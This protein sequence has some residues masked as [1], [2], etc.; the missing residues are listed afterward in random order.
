MNKN[1]LLNKKLADYFS[2]QIRNSFSDGEIYIKEIIGNNDAVPLIFYFIQK[3]GNERLGVVFNKNNPQCEDITDKLIDKGIVPKYSD[4]GSRL[5]FHVY[6]FMDSSEENTYIEFE[7]KYDGKKAYS[8]LVIDK[9]EI[10]TFEE[11]TNKDCELL[12]KIDSILGKILL[13]VLHYKIRKN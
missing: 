2:N 12:K 9:D 13:S 1:Q 7:Y 3:D 5:N 11:F 6:K 10:K 8:V 4:L